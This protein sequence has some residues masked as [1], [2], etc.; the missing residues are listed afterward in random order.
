MR[1]KFIFILVLCVA[2]TFFRLNAQEVT[3]V[4]YQVE[5]FMNKGNWHEARNTITNFYKT[6]PTSGLSETQTSVRNEL[7]RLEFRVDAVIRL[8]EASYAQISNQAS[9]K[10]CDVYLNTYPYGKYRV[11][12]QWAKAKLLNTISGYTEFITLNPFSTLANDARTRLAAFEEGSIEKARKSNSIVAFQEYLSNYPSGIYV[13]EARQKV[14]EI[15]EEEAFKLAQST[16]TVAAYERYLASFPTGKYAL[17]VQNIIEKVYLEAGNTYFLQKNWSSAIASYQ[18]LVDK[19]PSSSSRLFV[20]QR[21]KSANRKISFAPKSMT[22]LSF[23]RDNLSQIGFGIGSFTKAGGGFYY[24][25][26]VTK[27]M[28]GRGG[29]L[30]T[31]DEDGYTSTLT[32][33]RL[34]GDVQYNNMG[35]L[36]G[37][38]FK[39]YNPVSAYVGGGVLNEALYYESDEYEFGSGNYKRTVWLKYTETQLTKFIGEAGIVANVLQKGIAKVG[40]TYYEKE[41]YF[42]FGLGVK[43]GK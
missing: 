40:I 14:G 21:I 22:Y 43:I 42:H 10:E 36:M 35:I 34:T 1:K 20:E 13:K 18:T 26:R 27:D 28:F 37:F 12:V 15:K 17:D 2:S 16:N 8:E 4:V 23:E 33:S 25:V 6:L 38:N 11:E 30:Y 5:R 24:K 32:E 41:V 3:S 9:M 29:I 39:I 31:I 7:Q 19:F